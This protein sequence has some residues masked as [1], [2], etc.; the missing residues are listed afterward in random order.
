MEAIG[1]PMGGGALKLE[2][3]HL[4]QILLPKLSVASKAKLHD[5]GKSL[6]RDDQEKLREIDRIVLGPF[7]STNISDRIVKEFTDSLRH[8]ANQLASIRQRRT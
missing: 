8:V 5:L 3:T 4:R 6:F 7:I 1:T 2:A